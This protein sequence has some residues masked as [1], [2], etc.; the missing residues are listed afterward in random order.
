MIMIDLDLQRRIYYG[1]NENPSPLHL[2]KCSDY[3]V[4]KDEWP[5]IKGK[6]V[7]GGPHQL[8]LFLYTN[9]KALDPDCLYIL[10]D[11]Y[12]EVLKNVQP[13]WSSFI[14]NEISFIL[15]MKYHAATKK[16]KCRP[17][18]QFYRRQ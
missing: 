9:L 1:I 11:K 8:V 18:D 12:P 7:L 17:I 6:V 4:S 5:A 3:I 16:G 2:E 10:I 13:I 15:P 14:W